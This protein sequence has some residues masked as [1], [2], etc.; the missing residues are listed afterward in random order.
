MSDRTG[1][2]L[3]PRLGVDEGFSQS[4]DPPLQEFLLEIWSD[5]AGQ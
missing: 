1:L 4:L 3:L 2:P 5:P